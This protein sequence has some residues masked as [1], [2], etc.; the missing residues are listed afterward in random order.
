MIGMLCVE[1]NIPILGETHDGNSSDKTL[2]NK[3]LTRISKD[4]AKNGLGEG[5]FT[6]V[7]DSAMVTEANL[8]CF[9]PIPD[10]APFYF[11]T[12]LP[13]TYGQADEAR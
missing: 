11:V 9:D 4:L 7:A 2:N 8:A 10:A 12:R 1:H 6:D 5:A 13:H 3:L